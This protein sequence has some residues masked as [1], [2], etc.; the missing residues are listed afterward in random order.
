[1]PLLPAVGRKQLP[2]RIGWWLIVGTLC[3][4]IFLHLI[5]FYF[6]IM[7]TFKTG[8]ELIAMPPTW[9]PVH[10][11]TAAWSL[12]LD[13]LDGTVL[14][15]NFLTY[16]VNSLI[17]TVGT[18]ALSTPITAFAAYANSKL[19]RGPIGR[20]TFLFLISTM[21]LPG[22]VSL[23]PSYLL[24]VHFPFAWPLTNEQQNALPSLSL[25]DSALAIIVPAT[26]NTLGFLYFKAYFDTIPNSILQAARV[27]GGSE[28]NIFRRI[29]VPMSVPVFAVVISNQFAGIWDAFLWPSLVFSSDSNLPMSVAIYRIINLFTSQ[30]TLN[31]DQIYN[32]SHIHQLADQGFTWSGLLVLSIFQTI[33]IFVVFCLS[34]RYLLRGIRL[35]GLR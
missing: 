4:G 2:I 28:F 25:F 22:V 29:V 18:I 12:A 27:D 26:F 3:L 14:Q 5:P 31:Q 35:R 7:T 33:P 13:V 20:W 10:P 32:N 34:F 11:T 19:Q 1:M 24:I 21:M 17:M 8:L 15:T 6:M 9:W 23:V 16:F 30:G